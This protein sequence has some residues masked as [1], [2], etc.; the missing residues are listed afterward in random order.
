M[1]ESPGGRDQTTGDSL[2]S[3]GLAHPFVS[4]HLR[5]ST[6]GG[7]VVQIF[8]S[9]AV[10][11][12]S[13]WAVE[14]VTISIIVR[15][16]KKGH[17]VLTMCQALGKPI[18]TL[19]LVSNKFHSNPTWAVRLILQMRTQSLGQL[20]ASVRASTL[21]PYSPPPARSQLLTFTQLVFHT[22]LETDLLLAHSVRVLPCP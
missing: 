9:P 15:T 1:P 13:P 3:G 12:L 2:S 8:P 11:K 22:S 10:Q 14:P 21:T 19:I 4:Q 17:S 5:G 16:V 6:G 7:C 18:Y 20:S